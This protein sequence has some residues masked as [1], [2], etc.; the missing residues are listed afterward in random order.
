MVVDQT[1]SLAGVKRHD[2]LPFGEEIGAGTGGRTAAQGYEGDV[3]GNRKRWAQ[4]ERDDETG[5][6]YAQARYYSSTQGRFTS[7]DEF[8][9]GPDELFDFTDAVADNPTF[10]ADLRKPQS[11]N[12]YQYSY[13][14]PLR[15]ID[16]NGHEPDDPDPQIPMPL[17]LPPAVPMPISGAQPQQVPNPIE[18]INSLLDAIVEP[19]KQSSIGKAMRQTVGVE[20]QVTPN[21]IPAPAMPQTG[22]PPSD[23]RQPL[24]PPPPMQA[25]GNRDQRK[26]NQGHAGSAKN[27]VDRLRGE[28]DRLRSTPNKDK[29][30]AIKEQLRRVERELQRQLDRMRKSETHGRKGKGT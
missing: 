14:N 8:T 25:R 22:T 26:V 19:F 6:D 7:P 30:P 27:E 21:D 20:P 16:P 28:R 4:L 12:K 9:G 2:Y 17:P 13:N 29:D 5:L 1:G 10:Y 3:D 18:A 23:Q 15:Y 24:P 11:L